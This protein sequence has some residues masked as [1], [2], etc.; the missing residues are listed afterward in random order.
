MGI[1]LFPLGEGWESKLEWIILFLDR[2]KHQ[3]DKVFC[4]LHGLVQ[5]FQVI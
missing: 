5:G 4:M 2:M 1:S 3:E